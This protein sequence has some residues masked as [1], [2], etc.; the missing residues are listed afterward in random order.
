MEASRADQD[1]IAVGELDRSPDSEEYIEY[2][3][4]LPACL[5]G[6][7][8]LGGHNAE[9]RVCDIPRPAPRQTATPQLPTGGAA[10]A[11][12]QGFLG[13]SEALLKPTQNDAQALARGARAREAQWWQTVGQV[14][15]TCCA[16]LSGSAAAMRAC[17]G[18]AEE[19]RG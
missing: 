18:G 1:E 14:P 2:V 17:G 5:M 13:G 3:C 8:V 12:P 10:A 6:L 19:V 4:C 15:L 16:R 7:C 11:P 9:R